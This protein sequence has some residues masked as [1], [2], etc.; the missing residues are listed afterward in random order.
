LRHEHRLT[1]AGLPDSSARSSDHS[2]SSHQR[3]D[4]GSPGCQR[5]CP[6]LDRLRH[7]VEGSPVHADRIEFT[8]A[9][10][11]GTCVTDWSFSLRCSP[12]RITATQLRLNTPRL[13]AAGERTLTAPTQHHLRRTTADRPG[14]QQHSC[15]KGSGMF[16]TN[17]TERRAAGGDRPRS[18]GSV[19]QLSRWGDGRCA[20]FF[21][22]WLL[23]RLMPRWVGLPGVPAAIGRPP[24]H[25]LPISNHG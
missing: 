6:R 23:S 7:S 5:I 19:K 24:C 21:T 16:Q 22:K 2:V 1:P 25:S 15:R 3:D 17:S 20:R 11:S 8:T 12:P 9:P 10:A 14:P 13:F 18:G 4:R